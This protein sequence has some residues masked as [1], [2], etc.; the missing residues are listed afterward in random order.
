MMRLLITVLSL[1]LLTTAHALAQ[2]R[3]YAGLSAGPVIF[4]DQELED[5]ATELEIDYN[6]PGYAI[7]G[8]VGYAVRTNIR[9][10]GEISYAAVSA[11][12]TIQVGGE[13]IADEDY[14]LSIW[15]L[16]GAAY[17]DLWPLYTYVPY[18]GGGAGISRV[19]NDFAIVDETQYAATVF[20]EAGIPFNLT[21]WV[22]I[23]PLLRFNWIGTD[24][25]VDD[26]FVDN[27]FNLQP[28]VSMRYSF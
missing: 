5:G 1:V 12:A 25:D 2:E 20:A 3:F 8:H 18:V 21:P 15:S 19:D 7:A 11:D 9:V 27:T 28:R 4:F 22:S 14:D 26:A 17:F 16:T 10:E 6:K 24:E 13:D 23:V